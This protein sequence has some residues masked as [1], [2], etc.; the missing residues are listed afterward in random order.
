MKKLKKDNTASF[1]KLSRF[2]KCAANLKIELWQ[3]CF[4]L[5]NIFL[6]LFFLRIV[7]VVAEEN[8]MRKIYLW[9]SCEFFLMFTLKNSFQILFALSANGCWMRKMMM[10]RFQFG[11]FSPWRSHNSDS[12]WKCVNFCDKS[13]PVSLSILFKCNIWQRKTFFFGNLINTFSYSSNFFLEYKSC[14]KWVWN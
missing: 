13:R 6:E 9:N 1:R 7:S 11:Y 4:C 2:S 12:S 5:S 10:L 3:C 8:C 14:V